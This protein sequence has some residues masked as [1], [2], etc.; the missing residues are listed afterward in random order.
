MILAV[1]V[2]AVCILAGTMLA[3]GAPAPSASGSASSLEAP[4]APSV[5]ATPTHV[6]SCWV[7][8][9]LVGDANPAEIAR[10][11]CGEP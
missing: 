9:D 1:I 10:T 6:E 7:T 4:T 5:D 2:L 11:L 8:G 3:S